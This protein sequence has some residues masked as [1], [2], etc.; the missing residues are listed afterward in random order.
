MA[1]DL[2]S[3]IAIC[4]QLALLAL[5]AWTALRAARAIAG[6]D[7]LDRWITG[8]LAFVAE[9]IVLALA[10]GG[11]GWLGGAANLA[12]FALA[13]LGVHRLTGHRP[14]GGP[15]APAYDRTT[16]AVVAGVAC[17]F[18]LPFALR[19]LFV[20]PVDWD[21]LEYH[22]FLPTTWLQSGR[23]ASLPWPYPLNYLSFYPANGELLIAQLMSVARNDLFAE[24]L[25]LP[26]VAATALAAAALARELGSSRAGAVAAGLW[27][28][29]TPAL[30]S[31]G[32]TGYVEPLLDF[33]LIAALVFTL[34]LTRAEARDELRLAALVG[35]AAGV[36]VGTKYTA[37]PA[38]GLF[39]A[40]SAVRL[41]HAEKRAACLG[42]L[43][44]P[45]VLTGGAWYARN[46]WLTGNPFYPVP[47]LGLPG[48]ANPELPWEGASIASQLAMLWQSG[49]LLATH[50]GSPGSEAGRMAI[51]WKLWL[52]LPLAAIGLG[53]ALLLARRTGAATTP[54]TVHG[55]VLATAAIL[56]TTYL[57]TPYW[58]PDSWL[59]ANVRFLVPFVAVAVA[60]G[61]AAL[62]AL[63]ARPAHLVA[64]AL[65]GLALDLPFV[66]L[67]VPGFGAVA[68]VV[69]CTAAGAGAALAL[70]LLPPPTAGRRTSAMRALGAAG[71][72]ALLVL[73]FAAYDHRE[74]HRFDQYRNAV[75]LHRSH[76]V[77]YVPSAR[78]LQEIAPGERLAIAASREILF[79]YLFVGPRLERQVMYTPTDAARTPSYRDPG[80]SPRRILDREAWLRNL[81]EDR[82]ALLLVTRRYLDPRGRGHWP[83]EH[84]W[85]HELGFEVLHADPYAT[86]FRTR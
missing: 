31:Y 39:V 74:R 65:L 30:L 73:S 20:V 81:R 10:L 70:A 86:V 61:I 35:L 63:G 76:H 40:W 52:A 44:V 85:A 57:T 8:F 42:A 36:A 9:G 56:L 47:V 33:A 25:T 17:L 4:G 21:S 7:P 79:P 48:I 72:V 66:D 83:I 24:S 34:R 62:E 54:R 23:L 26:A 32:A 16:L 12:A 22:L 69:L 55:L 28:A 77:L 50:V 41:L 71:A 43:A 18:G 75:E 37:L 60:S 67:R 14:A 68:S 5:W 3:A 6:P 64:L 78:R 11:I 53:R 2:R 19:A 82:I 27:V 38:A 49:L 46:A 84:R 45:L 29:T 51:G 59:Q 80:G 13:G 1:L 58:K 15:C